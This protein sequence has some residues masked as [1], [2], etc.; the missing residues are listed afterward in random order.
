MR[1]IFEVTGEILRTL[2]EEKIRFTYFLC[3]T[4]ISRNL[5]PVMHL[6]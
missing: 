5:I 4:N 2:N 6:G 3:K 1:N